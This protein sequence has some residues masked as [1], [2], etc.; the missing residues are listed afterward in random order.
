MNLSFDDRTLNGMNVL[1]VIV[2]S[3]SFA[4][5]GKALNLS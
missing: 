3:G 4:A 2:R 1:A 5:A